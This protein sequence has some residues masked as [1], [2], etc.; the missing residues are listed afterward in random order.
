MVLA[1]CLYAAATNRTLFSIFFP[2][3]LHHQTLH[4]K[5]R[6]FYVP[7]LYF[8]TSCTKK[9]FGGYP[10]LQAQCSFLFLAVQ[11]RWHMAIPS[12]HQFSCHIRIS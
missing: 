7:C 10:K 8:V 12:P 5:H 2:Y 11:T 6:R 1:F 3:P 9:I 4:H